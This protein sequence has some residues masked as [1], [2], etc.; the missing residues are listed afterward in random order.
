MSIGRVQCQRIDHVAQP[1]IELSV[2][3]ENDWS[4]LKFCCLARKLSCSSE[5]YRKKSTCSLAKLFS[6]LVAA[7]LIPPMSCF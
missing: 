4:G 6:R 1:D 2:Y 5:V 7:L 3:V